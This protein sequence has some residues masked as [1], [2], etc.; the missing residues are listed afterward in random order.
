MK[1]LDD[2]RTYSVTDCGACF[3]IRG[4]HIDSVYKLFCTAPGGR[5][6]KQVSD[7]YKR[8]DWCPLPILI[9]RG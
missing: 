5:D 4:V 9:E 3:F 2:I 1:S 7:M 8:Q 6:S